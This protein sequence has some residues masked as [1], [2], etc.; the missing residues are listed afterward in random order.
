MTPPKPEARIAAQERYTLHLAGRI[1][2]LAQDTDESL[3]GL[4]QDNKALFDHVQLGFRQAHDF[5]QER[6]AEIKATL[7]DHTE[8]LDTLS[9]DVS[10]LKSAQ[11]EQGQ[12]LKEILAL[13]KQRPG[14]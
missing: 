2:E 11:A 6:F 7:K 13:L 1:E 3:R 9:K 5:A 10:E 4:Q 14:E 12:I 8:G